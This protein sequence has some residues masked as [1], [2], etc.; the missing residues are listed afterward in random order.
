MN[1]LERL[2]P[3]PETKAVDQALVVPDQDLE[4]DEIVPDEGDC[5]EV[6]DG[7]ASA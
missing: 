5:Q 4:A 6:G 2:L 1:L 3:D 7:Q